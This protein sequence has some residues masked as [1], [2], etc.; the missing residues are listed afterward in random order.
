MTAEIPPTL[1]ITNAVGL[2]VKHKVTESGAGD[3]AVPAKRIEASTHSVLDL[4][5]SSLLDAY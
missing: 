5:S 3:A 2:S 1:F 4:V